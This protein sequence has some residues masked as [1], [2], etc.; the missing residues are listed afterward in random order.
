MRSR[1]PPGPCRR[2]RACSRAGGPTSFRP[3][4]RRR[5]T[6]PTPRSPS[7]LSSLGYDT[8][9]FVANLDYCGRETGLARGFTHYEDY[10]LSAVGGLQPLHRPWPQDRPDLDRDGRG[11]PDGRALGRGAP[12]RSRSRGSTPRVPRTSTGVSWTGSPGSAP[13]GRPFFAFLNYNDAHTPYEV[14]D[15]SA[16]GFGIR[17]SSWHD[18]LVLQQWNMLDKTKLPFHERADGQRPLRRRDRLSRP[19]AGRLARRA[20]AARGARRHGGDRDLGPRG[21]P[22]RPPA[23]LPRLQPVPATR[24]GAAGHRRSPGGAGRPGGRRSR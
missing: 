14:P 5:S 22:R 1:R 21:T 7:R 10:P 9:G 18:R 24:R 4:G 11:H 15:D 19:A 17:P 23:V 12:P 2:T 16:R 13:A 20:A 8:A 3:A 6:T